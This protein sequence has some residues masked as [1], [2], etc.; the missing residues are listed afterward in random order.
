MKK[1]VKLVQYK[2]KFESE[3]SGSNDVDESTE[4]GS[5]SDDIDEDN[6]WL[7]CQSYLDFC[8]PSLAATCES[9][10]GCCDEEENDTEDDK[11]EEEDN[12]D[13]DYDDGGEDKFYVS[14]LEEDRIVK[15]FCGFAANHRPYSKII[16][17]CIEPWKFHPKHA[18][19]WPRY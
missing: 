7:P 11:Y 1:A 12:D 13:V 14:T 2:T 8:K 6:D 15:Q 16:A 17:Y 10:N 9:E 4:E 5:N 19:V 18:S 3:C